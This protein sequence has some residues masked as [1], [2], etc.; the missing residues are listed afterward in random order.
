MLKHKLYTI[1]R[2]ENNAV[3]IRLNPESAILKGHFPGN[4]I[5]PGVCQ[6]GIVGEVAGDICGVELSLIEVKILKFIEILRPSDGD[7][8]V[9]FDKLDQSDNTVVAKGTVMSEGRVFT[10]FSLVFGKEL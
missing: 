9:V 4:P 6:V 2:K 5:T 3:R 7:V 10:K 1:V 8:A